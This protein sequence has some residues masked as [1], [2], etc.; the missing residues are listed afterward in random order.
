LF[1][2][3]APTALR[4]YL[5]GLLIGAE[6]AEGLAWSGAAAPVIIGEPALAALYAQALAAAGAASRIGPADAALRGLRRIATA[7]GM[8]G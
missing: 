5:S 3:E 8:V 4:G 6:V 1:A 7:A 2:R